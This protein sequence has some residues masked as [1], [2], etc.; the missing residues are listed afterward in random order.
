MIKLVNYLAPFKEI[1]DNDPDTLQLMK[2]YV[3][4]IVLIDDIVKAIEQVNSLF[5]EEFDEVLDYWE[6]GIKPEKPKGS[7]GYA[8]LYL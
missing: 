3:L 1:W 4:R 7:D 6:T 2:G 5:E 8:E